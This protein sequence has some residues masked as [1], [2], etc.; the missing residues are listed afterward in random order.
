M[1][2]HGYLPSQIIDTI[3]IPIIKDR[4]GDITSKD[5]YRPIAVTT[6]VS[7][8]FKGI[9]LTLYNNCFITSPNRFGFKSD[10]STDMCTFV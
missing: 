8:M 10:H 5:Y 1:V 2:L 3:I 7:K 9:L 4:K 6:V